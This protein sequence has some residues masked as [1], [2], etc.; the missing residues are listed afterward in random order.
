MDGE[1]LREWNRRVD[2]LLAF[3]GCEN[4]RE[5]FQLGYDLAVE[6][7]KSGMRVRT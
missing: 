5:A 4:M 6:Q 2:E 1:K 7:V 3:N